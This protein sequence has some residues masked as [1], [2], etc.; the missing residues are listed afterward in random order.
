M[1]A[2]KLMDFA[3]HK[4]EYHLKMLIFQRMLE[5]VGFDV[6][7]IV[8]M[9]K[10][11]AANH[12]RNEQVPKCRGAYNET[13]HVWGECAE[14]FICPCGEKLQVSDEDVECACG[15]KYSIYH[16]LLVEEPAS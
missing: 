7:A 9:S 1:T 13:K 16:T 14:C 10:D 15:R 2:D 5:S 4:D 8:G 3:R 11:E 6:S 12:L